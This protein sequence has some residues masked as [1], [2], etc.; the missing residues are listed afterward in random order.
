MSDNV[1]FKCEVSFTSI[2]DRENLQKGNIKF[3]NFCMAVAEDNF[4]FQPGYFLIVVGQSGISK[5]WKPLAVSAK[6][7]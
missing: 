7:K 5:P 2:L 6:A 3:E 1:I 4:L